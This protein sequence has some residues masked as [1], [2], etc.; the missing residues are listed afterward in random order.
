M[1]T[2][3]CSALGYGGAERCRESPHLRRECLHFYDMPG[4]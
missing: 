2:H 3:L 1:L 4:A